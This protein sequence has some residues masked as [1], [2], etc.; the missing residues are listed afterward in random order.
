MDLT[1]E[2]FVS[3]YLTTLVPEEVSEEDR[4]D[5]S[6]LNAGP[7]DWREKGGVTPVKD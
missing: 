5:F 1:D 3:T 6:Y 7:V 4:V 2:E